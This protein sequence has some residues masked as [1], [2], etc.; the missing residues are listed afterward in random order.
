MIDESLFI[1]QAARSRL[2]NT[3][4]MTG[5]VNRRCH[6]P[7][8]LNMALVL[9][10]PTSYG[11]TVFLSSWI[12]TRVT[13]GEMIKLDHDTRHARDVVPCALTFGLI[14]QYH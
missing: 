1:E 7:R 14:I 10:Q 6:R 12:R 9:A 2:T 3:L 8:A 13:E 5:L 11:M 4:V